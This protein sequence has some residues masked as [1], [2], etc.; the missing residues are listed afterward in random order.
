[1]ETMQLVLQIHTKSVSAFCID[2][3]RTRTIAFIA[4]LHYIIII[5]QF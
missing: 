4:D 5:S 1:M 2:H 3:E